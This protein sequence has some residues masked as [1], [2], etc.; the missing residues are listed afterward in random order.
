M[1]RCSLS[2]PPLFVSQ[3]R[4]IILPSTRASHGS[5]S[6]IVYWRSAIIFCNNNT[7]RQ[8]SIVWAK[9]Y[10][11]FCNDFFGT[12]MDV[13]S[14]IQA[15]INNELTELNRILV[16]KLHCRSLFAHQRQTNTSY[17]HLVVRS[18]DRQHH[19]R[20]HSLGSRHRV[21]AQCQP[22]TRRCD[23]YLIVSSRT[24]HHQRYGG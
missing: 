19:T 24:T 9:F 6:I 17:S 3:Q 21:D 16:E 8:T 23:R 4:R 10:L 22:H 15:P 11:Y 20:Y 1:P 14:T 7:Y 12:T 5:L 2:Y 13:L 18:H